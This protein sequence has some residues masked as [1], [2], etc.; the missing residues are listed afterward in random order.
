MFSTKF[1]A[2]LDPDSIES[3]AGAVTDVAETSFFAAAERS[4]A[5]ESDPLLGAPA[6]WLVATVRF[7]ENDCIGAV[8]CLMSDELARMLF[9]AFTGRDPNDPA[10]PAAELFDL[11]GEF[12]N[13]VCGR[14]LT[15][16]VK[17]TTFDLRQPEVCVL[18]QQPALDGAPAASL[19]MN[20]NDLPLRVTI[21]PLD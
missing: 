14:W 9:D 13:M 3:L 16:M 17:G 11:A 1:S 7:E 6:Q 20:V 19:V 5:S 15:Q 21:R 4:T 10:P 8:S 2:L 18:P 12:S